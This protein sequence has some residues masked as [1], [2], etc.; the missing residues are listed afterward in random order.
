MTIAWLTAR[1]P[2]LLL[3][4]GA[5]FLCALLLLL[6]GGASDAQTLALPLTIPYAIVR[7]SLA[8]HVFAGAQETVPLL[9]DSSGCNHL[10]MA[11]PRIVGTSVGRL[12]VRARIDARGGTPLAGN[13]LLPFQWSGVVE[14]SE[15]AYIGATPSAI[16]FRIVD[17][18]ILDA[19]GQ[20][21]SVP[22]VVWNW[23]KQYVHPRLEAFTFDLVPLFGS[24]HD[25][26]AA[27]L[28]NAPAALQTSA[29]SLALTAVTA[30]E[31]ALVATVGINLPDLPPEL[32]PAA[33]AAPLNAREMIAWD[34]QW[35]AWDAFATWAVKTL[36]QPAPAE[37]RAALL[38]TLLTARYE[39]RD[40]L[41]QDT[42]AA[43]PVRS[44]FVSTWERLAP[45]LNRAELDVDGATAVRYLALLNAGD[46]LRTLDSA[47]AQLGLR[48]DQA[49]L[50]RLA[51]TLLPAVADSELVYSTAPDPALRS[52]LGLSP[53]LTSAAPTVATS[54]WRDWLISGA[55]AADVDAALIARLNHWLPDMNNL[56]AY[57]TSIEG[58]LGAIVQQEEQRS[59]VGKPFV[60][61]YRLLVR[62]TAWQETCWRQFVDLQGR[63]EPLRSSVG[64]VGLMQI[65]KHVWRGVYD[66]TRLEN[67]VAY[68]ARAGN[69]ILVQYLVDYA[70][71]KKEHEISGNVDNLA[72]SVYAMYN[73]GPGH[74][75][76]YRDP[77][78]QRE[79]RAI[80]SAFWQKY[81]ALQSTG[82]A[83]GA[84]VVKQCYAPS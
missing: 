49:T 29:D 73:G 56:E 5:R 4:P 81:Q 40:A 72:R 21:A 16:A 61:V 60:E 79:L 12:R 14:V 75:A 35:Q 64:S 42:L 44:L 68:N 65:N 83:N 3:M 7:N 67:D 13:C 17:S 55:Y 53:E 52:L 46:A 57:L 11:A 69:E 24:T 48:I 9:R 66:V 2:Q 22:G 74:L 20:K 70:I 37:L 71:K 6:T 59:K 84:R 39:L 26:L 47:G 76:R 33:P 58:V 10:T 82:A 23:I 8:E 38:E 54:R 18:N 31:Q 78:E 19:H 32:L 45:L 50:R 63:I 28:R 25:L 30:G 43:D 15:Q 77:Q 1:R 41:A 36:A 51:R 27:A 34:T 62:A 80:D